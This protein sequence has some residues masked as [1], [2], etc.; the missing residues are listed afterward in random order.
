MPFEV[1]SISDKERKGGVP[2]IA[3]CEEL[4]AEPD[5]PIPV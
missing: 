5:I 4:R 1:S 3:L 2:Y